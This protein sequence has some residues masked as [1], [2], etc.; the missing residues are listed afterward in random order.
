M[1]IIATSSRK[2]RK[3]HVP[4]VVENSAKNHDCVINSYVLGLGKPRVAVQHPPSQPII[5]KEF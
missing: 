2:D 1:K 3:Q 4:K 5:H